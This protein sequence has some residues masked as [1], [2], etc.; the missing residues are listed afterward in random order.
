MPTR[1]DWERRRL[2]LIADMRGYVE[3]FAG[4]DV[5]EC[6]QLSLDPARSEAPAAQRAL[7]CT[8]ESKR[9]RRPSWMFGQVQAVES[10]AFD[11]ILVSDD[12]RYY[13][14]DFSER[15]G[16]PFGCNGDFEIAECA[17]TPHIASPRSRGAKFQCGPLPGSR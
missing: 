6:G 10:I 11:G 1:A 17:E 5:Y 3:R 8:I 16:N 13:H 4:K 9:K 12:E 7:E 2:E 15:C 14:F